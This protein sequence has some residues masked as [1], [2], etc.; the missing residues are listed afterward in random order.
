MK[1][2][3]YIEVVTVEKWTEIENEGIVMRKKREPGEDAE[4]GGISSE[5]HI[6][7]RP[8]D[9]KLSANADKT[10]D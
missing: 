4:K 3:R 5:N 6:E 9:D 10:F 1:I 2:V 8:D 7:C